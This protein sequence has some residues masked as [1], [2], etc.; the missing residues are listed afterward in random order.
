MFPCCLVS[1]PC[2][3][4]LSILKKFYWLFLLVLECLYWENP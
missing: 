4:V 1:L 3:Q 2:T